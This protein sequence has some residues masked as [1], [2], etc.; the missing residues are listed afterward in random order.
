[1]RFQLHQLTA[2][3][4]LTSSAFAQPR[5]IITEIMYNPNSEEK[6]GRSEWVEIAN[7]GTET[8]ELKDWR[9]DD[10]DKQDWGRF[11]CT[12]APGAVLVLVDDTVD[13]S[14]FRQA[15]DVTPQGEESAAL[16]NYQ[17]I[18]IKWASLA[19]APGPANE[20]LQLR[21]HKDEVVCQIKQEG[22]WPSCNKPDGPS[23]WLTDLKATELSD[24]KIWRRS[25]VGKDGARANNT[26]A[27]F[28]GADIGS[29]GFV[30][31]LSEVGASARAPVKPTPAPMPATTQPDEKP[32]QSDDVIDY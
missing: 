11:T 19:N 9:L 26:T 6:S 17:I 30:P 1:M 12:L 18:P 5:I 29:P 25:E 23:I 28:N 2:I 27:I 20:V 24:G 32:S 8:I 16:I 21:N 14:Q 31:G 4:A 10:E 3:V 22:D 15:W 7:V 13:E